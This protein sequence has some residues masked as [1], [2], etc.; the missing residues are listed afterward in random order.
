VLDESKG[1]LNILM[2]NHNKDDQLDNIDLEKNLSSMSPI[3]VEKVNVKPWKG[4]GKRS[5]PGQDIERIN[6]GFS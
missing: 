1:R 3:S 4:K 6:D 2:H 5:E